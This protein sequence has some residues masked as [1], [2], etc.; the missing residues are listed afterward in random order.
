VRAK[1]IPR[2]LLFPKATWFNI[3]FGRSSDL[4]RICL[5]FPSVVYTESDIDLNKSFR[6]FRLGNYSSGYCSGF[7]PDSLLSMAKALPAPKDDANVF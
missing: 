6:L 2:S 3:F 7:T 5:V 1:A 4:Y